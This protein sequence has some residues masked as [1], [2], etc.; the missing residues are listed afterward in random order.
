[1]EQEAL[2]R[3]QLNELVKTAKRQGMYVS[4]EQ[5]M[6]AFPELAGQEQKLAF[7]YEYLNN[8]KISVGEKTAFE[9]EL[10]EED[11]DYLGQY[12]ESIAKS[13]CVS[14]EEKYEIL[15]S[16]TAGSEEAKSR[17]LEICLPDVAQIAKLYTGQGVYIEDLIGEGNVALMM[18]ID[19]L[20]CNDEA[21]EADG[22][23][24]NII[25]SAME[26]LVEEEQ[27]A[28]GADQKLLEMVNGVAMAAKELAGEF[29]RK[30][31][32]KEL[33]GEGD[34]SEEEIREALR[35]T[36]NKIEDIEAE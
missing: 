32:V 15:L 20:E 5:V 7:V 24:A 1:M 17:L 19:M 22:F 11:R 6:Q 3:K 23:I 16:A 35:V 33:A 29:R 31:T 18:A 2:F 26:A 36:A 8:V 4:T 14:E 25:M 28:D 13:G 9:A 34:Y 30:V 27:E 10:S 21:K 12:L